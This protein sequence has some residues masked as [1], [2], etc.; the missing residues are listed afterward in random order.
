MKHFTKI[1]AHAGCEHTQPNTKESL[2]TAL[3]SGADS[4]EVDVR[5]NTQGE[6]VLSHDPLAKETE[7]FKLTRVFE[8]LSAYPETYINCDL[9]ETGLTEK[10]LEMAKSM[11]IAHRL[12]LSGSVDLHLPAEKRPYAYGADLYLNAELLVQDL[13]TPMDV[14]AHSKIIL[15]GALALKAALNIDYR[16]ISSEFLYLC[17]AQGI[18]VSAW[19]LDEPEDIQHFLR[20][21]LDNITTN[22]VQLAC[23]MRDG[24]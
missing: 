18:K 20:M 9:K 1:T 23:R 10:V 24:L 2:L 11:Q 21:G 7:Y 8:I 22:A 16:L 17:K 14:I 19:T 5:K 15:L 12:I 13:N 3:H 6:L 4:F